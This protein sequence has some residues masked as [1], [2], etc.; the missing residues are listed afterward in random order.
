VSEVG[1]FQIIGFFVVVFA[2]GIYIVRI[3]RRVRATKNQ[4]GRLSI[5]FMKIE[6]ELSDIHDTLFVLAQSD[7]VAKST[8]EKIRKRRAVQLRRIVESGDDVAKIMRGLEFPDIDEDPAFWGKDRM[9]KFGFADP[10]TEKA[11][12]SSLP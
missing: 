11:Q 2:F 12:E 8:I 4:L 3:D 1:V 6:A 5:T 10:E 9:Q 7:A